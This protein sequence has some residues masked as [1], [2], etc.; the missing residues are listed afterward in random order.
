MESA[1]T[2]GDMGYRVLLVEKEASIGGKMILL[3]KVFPTLDCSSCISTPKMAATFNHPMVTTYTSSEVRSIKKDPEGGFKV[4]VHR[5][6]TFVDSA[7]CTGC[8]QCEKVCT[9]ARPD[10][11]NDGL[12][13]RRAIYIPFPQAVP[14]KAVIER[15]GL[16]PCSR[17]CPAGVK[18]HALVA[19]IRNGRISRAYER[20]L[21]DAPFIG[22]LGY[23][24]DASCEAHCTVGKRTK[25]PIPIRS[26]ER[27][28]AYWYMEHGRG[29][30]KEGVK[31]APAAGTAKKIVCLGAG[32]LAL[33]VS[34]FL[35]SK[36]HRVKLVTLGK[37]PGGHLL[38]AVNQGHVPAHILSRD[39]K[40][41]ASSGVEID[42][43]ST[44]M[45]L[46]KILEGFDAAFIEDPSLE[47][48]EAPGV[49]RTKGHIDGQTRLA[50]VIGLGRLYAKKIT[51]YLEGAPFDREYE[52]SIESDASSIAPKEIP[53]QKNEVF[54]E[55]KAIEAASRCLDCA[56]C[57][58]CQEC[59][60]ACPAN[61]IDFSMKGE[62]ITI[63]TKSIIAATG[64]K[65]FD[66][67]Q[68]PLLGYKKFA[69]CITAMQM[70]RLLAPTRPY[71][72]VLRPSD[73]KVPGNIAIVLCTGSRDRTIGNTWCSRICCMY[74]IKQ[75]Q[76]IMGA[77]PIANVTL[78]Y[79]DIR[80]F[81]KAYDE[82]Y[83]QAKAMGTIF[84]KGKVAKI[85]EAPNQDLYPI[86]KTWIE[87]V[88]SSGQSTIS[89]SWPLVH[90]P[91]QNS[92]GHSRTSP[93]G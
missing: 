68:K 88:G 90:W 18:A 56:V 39:L 60:V 24:C 37:E 86:L 62:T 13:S 57:S 9:V 45:G 16:S 71:N 61:A 34:Y 15:K 93:W 75:A 23:L 21:E 79:I 87:R 2:L 8:G 48:E 85:E 26:L 49:F 46:K 50:E 44:Q 10:Q 77:L 25:T 12:I 32:P 27:F 35:A 91:R 52:E 4:E 53:Q 17:S 74:S 28:L 38:D 64:F 83:E 29:A 1:I 54:Q 30:S 73:G 70:D 72:A 20:F 66:P 78:Y 3:S 81:G 22:T 14:K 7:K 58:Q 55:D 42:T 36:G 6:A 40:E 82:F 43:S 31:K 11:F 47:P 5:R 65:L 41:I 67:A 69:N 33:S 19:L 80:A 76:L 84:V 92:K 51:A 89:W 59:Q 63:H